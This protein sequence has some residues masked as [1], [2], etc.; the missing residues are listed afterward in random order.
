VLP[1]VRTRTRFTFE[2]A[3]TDG[4][5]TSTR[6]V[7][8]TEAVPVKASKA[9]KRSTGLS[10][11]DAA[12]RAAITRN[13]RGAAAA[14]RS[15]ARGATA[16]RRSAAST[17]A[18]NARAARSTT[19]RVR[20]A[21]GPII[22]AQP[23]T[24]VT[25]NA[26]LQGRWTGEVTYQWTQV[27]GR[28]GALS[29]TSGGQV[30]ARAPDTPGRIVVRVRA[31]DAVGHVASGQVIVNA[32]KAGS[33]QAAAV[34]ASAARAASSGKP[35]NVSLPGGNT[36]TL[37]RLRAMR[38]GMAVSNQADAAYAF[39]GSELKVGQVSIT[40]ASGNVSITGIQLDSGTLTFPAA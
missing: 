32:G 30:R 17:N 15:A 29:G 33:P 3:I 9:T 22:T 27:S 25:L 36:A 16:G 35:L 37:K 11:A 6:T 31:R 13:Q 23:G 39:N 8:A 24:S 28:A 38:G 14:R 10:P 21:D 5:A 20:I 18:R 1:L 19:P 34:M 12:A 4:S 7:T 2:L 26:R 40:G